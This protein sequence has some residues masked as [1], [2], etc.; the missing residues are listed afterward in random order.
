MK[1]LRSRCHS[2]RANPRVVDTD[3]HPRYTRN[4][5]HYE[6]ATDMEKL[7]RLRPA[8]RRSGTVT[9]GNSSG[10]NDGSAALLLMSEE[11]ADEL[12][13]KPLARWVSSAAAGVDPRTMG[14]GPIPA[15]RKALK[16]ADLTVEDIGPCRTERGLC[17]AGAGSDEGTGFET[18][19]HQCQRRGGGVGTSTGLLRGAYIDDL[20]ARDEASQGGW[21]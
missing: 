9:A 16:R 14:L 2:A 20:V 21:E 15:T 12:G 5:G 3:E 8:F 7:G 13:L 11:K 6:L 1:Q 19:H 17:G 10:L 18:R 4:N